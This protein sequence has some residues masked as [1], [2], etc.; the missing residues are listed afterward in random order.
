MIKY[1]TRAV[2]RPAIFS[3]SV[4]YLV[5]VD[6][7]N[8]KSD[9]LGSIVKCGDAGLTSAVQLGASLESSSEAQTC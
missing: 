1:A 9:F 3:N 5:G 7:T 4:R 8:N 2:S 6:L